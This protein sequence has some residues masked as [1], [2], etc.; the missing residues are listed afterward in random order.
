M[1]GGGRAGGGASGGGRQGVEDGGGGGKGRGGVFAVLELCC[2][3]IGLV[4]GP[5]WV[6]AVVA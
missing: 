5:G 3:L 1:G 6:V 4:R 2:V